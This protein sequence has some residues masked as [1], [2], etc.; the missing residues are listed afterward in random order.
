ME[1]CG[2]GGCCPDMDI[3]ADTQA[4]RQAD[5]Q[6]DPRADRTRAFRQWVQPEL[7]LL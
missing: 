3:P 7:E 1:G 6:A 4:D 5:R 2:G